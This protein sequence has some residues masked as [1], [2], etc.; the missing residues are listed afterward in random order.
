[1]PEPVVRNSAIAGQIGNFQADSTLP[2]N[3]W[4]YFR[5]GDFAD[6]EKNAVINLD[7]SR[8]SGLTRPSLKT[9]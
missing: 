3:R 6:P 7:L 2:E 1:L 4:N 8:L 9:S 5:L